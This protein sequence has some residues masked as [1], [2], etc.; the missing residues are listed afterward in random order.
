MHDALEDNRLISD[1]RGAL[2]V[3]VL[4]D[5]LHLMWMTPTFGSI[6]HLA[7]TL[8]NRYMKLFFVGVGKNLEELG[9]W[10]NSSCGRQ[11]GNTQKMLDS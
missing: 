4:I 5:Y 8:Q 9:T 6:L 1:I 7:N 2:T 3:N 10:Q 11:V